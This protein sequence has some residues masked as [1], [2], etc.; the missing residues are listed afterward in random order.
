MTEVTEALGNQ[1]DA[2]WRHFGSCLRFDSTLI[3]TIETDNRG[4]TGCML[5][6]VTKWVNEDEGTG[7]LPRTWQTVVQAVKSSGRMQLANE[8]AKKYRVTLT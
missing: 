7:D 2:K 5:D 8:L 3:D 6:L 4:S 1:V